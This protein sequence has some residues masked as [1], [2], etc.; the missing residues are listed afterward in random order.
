MPNHCANELTITGSP[1][2]LNKFKE[3]AQSKKNKDILIEL[4]NFEQFLDKEKMITNPFGFSKNGDLWGTKWGC[5][6]FVA[7]QLR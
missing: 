4:N 1:K 2:E 7:R 5:Y 6:D 3:F